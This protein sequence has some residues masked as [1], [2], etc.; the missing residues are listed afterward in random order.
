MLLY[1]LPFL[2]CLLFFFVCFCF[3]IV[4]VVWLSL[5]PES[6]VL[7]ESQLQYADVSVPTLAHAALSP[8]FLVLGDIKTKTLPCLQGSQG[9]CSHLQLGFHL[10][11]HIRFLIL[12]R[13]II[14]CIFLKICSIV[15]RISMCFTAWG[16]SGYSMCLETQMDISSPW[17]SCYSDI[18][19]FI[20]VS[21]Y[22]SFY[23]WTVRNVS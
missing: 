14:T 1:I 3:V 15:F 12:F 8:C 21:M 22:M 6:M 17:L 5:S 19:V 10:T 7:W 11:L 20:F 18:S 13:H 9:S 23:M 16:F 4:V 2:V